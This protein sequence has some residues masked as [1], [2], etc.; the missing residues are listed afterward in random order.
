MALSLG[1]NLGQPEQQLRAGL[2]R[3]R[4][5]LSGIRIAPL[6]RSRPIGPPRQPDYL[7]TAVVARCRLAP[8]ELLALAKAVEREAGRRR[9]PRFG[10]R[11][12]DI[13]LLLFDGIVSAEPEL[14]LPHPRLAERRFYL[15]PLAR[16]APD[17]RVPPAGRT[18]AELLAAAPTDQE[19]VEVGWSVPPP[20]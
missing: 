7:N 17:L 4:G 8:D 9:G 16:L 19:V 14:T 11:L 6:F 15:E 2:E 13:D 1:A 20:V 18:V 5:A 10:P 3:L 12:L